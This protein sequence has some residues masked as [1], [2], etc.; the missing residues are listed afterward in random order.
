MTKVGIIVTMEGI[1]RLVKIIMNTLSLPGQRSLEKLKAQSDAARM[2]P[3]TFEITTISV[4]SK[5]RKYG[6]TS[7]AS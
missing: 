6:M 1:I 2:D 4:F 3:A 5:Y 7:S